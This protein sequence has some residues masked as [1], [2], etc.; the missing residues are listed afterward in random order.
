MKNKICIVC[1]EEITRSLPMEIEN[2]RTLCGPHF[3]VFEEEKRKLLELLGDQD[4]VG[5]EKI[6]TELAI[7]KTIR[8][9]GFYEQ[10]SKYA[11]LKLPYGKYTVDLKTLFSANVWMK[12]KDVVLEEL[13]QCDWNYITPHITKIERDKKIDLEGYLWDLR[14]NLKSGELDI[15]ED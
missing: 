1:S 14:G 15:V 7:Q 9:L 5:H 11:I 2:G 4:I 8:N 10:K 6:I 13:N 3:K 12:N